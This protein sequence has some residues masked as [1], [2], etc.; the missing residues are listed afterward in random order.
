MPSSNVHNSFKNLPTRHRAFVFAAMAVIAFLC[1]LPLTAELDGEEGPAL[2]AFFGRFHIV[3]LH[4]PIAWLLLVPLL[5][6]VAWKW[7]LDNIRA[8]AGIVLLLAALSAVVA[9]TLGFSLAVADAYAGSTVTAHMW[10]GIATACF[11]IIALLARELR[12]S[13]P[14]PLLAKQAY[15]VM[16]AASLVTVTLGGHLGGSLVQGEGY[17]T[18]RLPDSIKQALNI[19]TQEALAIDY[20]A[21]IYA[22]IIEPILKESCHSCHNDQKYKGKYSMSSY[23]SLLRGGKSDEAAIEP[24]DHE[25]SGIYRRVVLNN[26]DDDIMPPAENTPLAESEIALLAWWI[27]LGTPTDRAINDLE[28]EEFPQQIA[29]IVDDLMDLSSDLSPTGVAYDPEAIAAY[30]ES[31]KSDFGLDVYPLSQNPSDGLRVESLNITRPF[32]GEILQALMPISAYIRSL[33]IGE[34]QFEAGDF[35]A[36]ADFT[37]LDR[38]VL[39]NASLAVGELKFL[40]ELELRS[41]NLYSTPLDDEATEHLA[42][43][44]S[45]RNLYIGETGISAHKIESLASALPRCQILLSI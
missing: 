20:D 5:E 12:E 39:D 16:L 37:Y 45:L 2:L 42:Q 36:I 6:I 32:D 23:A 1:L 40:T 31:L 44:R 25:R 38:L 19:P 13:G 7:K 4:L 18:A 22:A 11:A 9:A 15:P 26:S 21:E 33:D 24:G 3:V 28:T 17:L 8:V 29:N 43:I 30:A 27:D 14:T 34:A 35:A 10:F 41:L